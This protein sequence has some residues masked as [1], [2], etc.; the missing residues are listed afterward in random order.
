MSKPF[1]KYKVF[2]LE[3][4]QK[5]CDEEQNRTNSINA[6]AS[7][8]TTLITGLCAATYLLCSFDHLEKMNSPLGHIYLDL[9]CISWILLIGSIA[10]VFCSIFSR[11]YHAPADMKKWSDWITKEESNDIADKTTEKTLYEDWI[12]NLSKSHEDQCKNNKLRLKYLNICH[13][14]ILCSIC[15]IGCLAASKSFLDYKENTKI[16]Q[17]IP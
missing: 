10:L 16:Q 2:F 3:L 5:S 14:V 17:F 9:M 8:L 13:I 15:C 7:Y 4:C 1:P 6:R 11:P 12:A